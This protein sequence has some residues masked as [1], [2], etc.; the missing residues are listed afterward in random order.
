MGLSK[1]VLTLTGRMSMFRASIITNPDFIAHVEN[2]YLN[3]WR[4]GQLKFLTGDDKSSWYW[5]LKNGWNMLYVPDVKMLRLNTR[6]KISFVLVHSLCSDGLAICCVPSER[7]LDVPPHITGFLHGGVCWIRIS[8]WTSLSGLSSSRCYVFVSFFFGS[9][10]CLDWIYALDNDLDIIDHTAQ[11]KLDVSIFI[12][13]NQIYGSF[14]KTCFFRLDRQ[15]WTRQKTKLISGQ[16]TWDQRAN[17]V[18]SSI[19]H[20]FSLLVLLP[21]MSLISGVIRI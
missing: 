8:M 6:R 1:R 12:N 5:V 16:G 4:F 20:I 19:L 10:F 11:D 15:S 7:A 14:I 21:F 2:D 3:H 13:Y 18:M 9:L 17:A